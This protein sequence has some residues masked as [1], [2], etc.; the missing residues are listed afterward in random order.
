MADCSDDEETRLL[1]ERAI[2]LDGL[3]FY[4]LEPEEARKARRALLRA[5]RRAANGELPK[6]EVAGRILDERSQEQFRV[7]AGELVNLL[8]PEDGGS[9]RAIEL[10]RTCEP[11][12][13]Q[14][15]L[16]FQ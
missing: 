13:S 6:V 7:A 4:L 8:L 9:S 1:F 15:V 3:H 12:E 5:A 11:N 10:E 16:R 14:R 2:A